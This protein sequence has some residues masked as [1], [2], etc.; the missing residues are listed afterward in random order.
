MFFSA[1]GQ[2]GGN[3]RLKD[4]RTP[5]QQAPP[6][7]SAPPIAPPPR[8]RYTSHRGGAMAAC[9]LLVLARAALGRPPPRVEGFRQQP[10]STLSSASEGACG[11]PAPGSR[12]APEGEPRHPASQEL[13]AAERLIAGLHQAACAVRPAPD[14]PAASAPARA[15]P[16]DPGGSPGRRGRSCRSSASGLGLDRRRASAGR[17]LRET[18]PH[19]CV[20]VGLGF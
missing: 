2:A 14:C 12:G 8:R 11:G 20:R 7:L 18:W 1:K 15:Q 16:P 13:T 5:P 6:P 9:G 10:S 17:V 3:R 19:S 4:S